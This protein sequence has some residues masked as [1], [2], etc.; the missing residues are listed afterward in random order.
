MRIVGVCLF[1]LSI[2]LAWPMLT[3]QT[4]PHIPFRA[5]LGMAVMI[6]ANACI[7]RR[8]A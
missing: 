8:A 5:Y 3:F 6:L 1:A 4:F 2:W 7:P